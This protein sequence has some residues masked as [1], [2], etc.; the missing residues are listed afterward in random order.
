M[1]TFHLFYY[2]ALS[3]AASLAGAGQVI[4]CKDTNGRPEI[5]DRPCGAATAGQPPGPRD[6]AIAVEHIDAKDIFSTRTKLRQDSTPMPPGAAEKLN[7]R[8]S[9]ERVY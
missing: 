2:V 3:C 6:P 5:T 9:G 4:H 7:R 8:A 1:N